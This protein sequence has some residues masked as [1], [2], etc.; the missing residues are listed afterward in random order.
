VAE[1]EEEEGVLKEPAGEYD[2]RRDLSRTEPGSVEVLEDVV[3]ENEMGLEDCW[4]SHASS[5]SCGVSASSWG[6]N[7]GM[8]RSI[9]ESSRV[10]SARVSL[11]T[12]DRTDHSASA[13]YLC[14]YY[15]GRCREGQPFIYF[16]RVPPIHSYFADKRDRG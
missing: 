4:M 10:A 2:L 16:Y 14:C 8:C 9:A 6:Y 5:S 13:S 7:D 3:A 12:V 15:H 1:E 11:I